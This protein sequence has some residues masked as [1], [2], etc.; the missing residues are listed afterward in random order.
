MGPL[1]G[2]VL[3]ESAGFE[4]ECGSP[5]SIADAIGSAF[6]DDDHL[7]QLAGNARAAYLKK[8]DEATSYTRLIEIY[9]CALV[10]WR[11]DMEGLSMPAGRY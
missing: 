11:T 4:F 8:Y 9:R 7:R 6:A 3:P 2:I 10:R 1:P 5:A